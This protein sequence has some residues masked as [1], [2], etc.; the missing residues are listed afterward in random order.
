[1]KRSEQKAGHKIRI[2]YLQKRFV[3]ENRL[4]KQPGLDKPPER[5]LLHNRVKND[6]GKKDRKRYPV[7]HR[8]A[9]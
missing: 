8:L 4:L 1:M 5:K 7:W 6:T 9:G 2:A 3:P